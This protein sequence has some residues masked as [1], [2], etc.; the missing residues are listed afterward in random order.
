MFF[1]ALR[2]L[3]SYYSFKDKWICAF[4]KISNLCK[5]KNTW[6][7]A[8]VPASVYV[9]V[10]IWV[11]MCVWLAGRKRSLHMRSDLGL[12]L[13]PVGVHWPG[14]RRQTVREKKEQTLVSPGHQPYLLL[15]LFTNSSYFSFHTLSS[16][17]WWT[18]SQP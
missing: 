10:C 7:Y 12:S 16:S 18:T 15:V 11:C 13:F 4:R 17:S 8:S 9:C 6:H 3:G 14:G 2:I 5:Q 1:I